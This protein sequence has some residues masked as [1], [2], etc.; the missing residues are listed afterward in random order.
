MSQPINKYRYFRIPTCNAEPPAQAS[1]LTINQPGSELGLS[2]LLDLIGHEIC[3]E[4]D[5]QIHRLTF[6]SG[7]TLCIKADSRQVTVRGARINFRSDSKYPYATLLSD[8]ATP[9][10]L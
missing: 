10:R 7:Q 2:N 8:P 5:K 6:K 3:Q 9:N 4:D 1:C